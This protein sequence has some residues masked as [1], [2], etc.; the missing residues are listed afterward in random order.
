MNWTLEWRIPWHK[1]EILPG[2][3]R[4]DVLQKVA[5]L[6]DQQASDIDI[7]RERPQGDGGIPYPAIVA[8]LKSRSIVP[9]LGAGV[10]AGN[11]CRAE[12]NWRSL[13]QPSAICALGI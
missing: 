4:D 13:L 10:S 7:T 3:S 8:G 12:L 9:F 11:D 5:E 1:P 2:I 6:L